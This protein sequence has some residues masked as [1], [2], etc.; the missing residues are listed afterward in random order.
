MK[1]TKAKPDSPR[2]TRKEAALYLPTTVQTLKRWEKQ[3]RIT[4]IY[5]GPRIVV[6]ERAELDALVA[7]CKS[8]DLKPKR[9]CAPHRETK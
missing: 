8:P 5:L 3:G 2:L 6:Y 4:P 1:T 9:P 7:G